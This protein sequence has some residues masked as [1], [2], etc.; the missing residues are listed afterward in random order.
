M[1]AGLAA[2]LG[3]TIGG[4]LTGGAAV[5]AQVWAS[6][7]QANAAKEAHLQEDRLWHR[8]Q[9]LEAHHKFL[10]QVNR[11]IHAAEA[12]A[13]PSAVAPNPVA[14]ES[15]FREAMALTVD[16]YNLIDLVSLQKELAAQVMVA[17]QTDGFMKAGEFEGVV[18]AIGEAS[19]IYRDAARA[20]LKA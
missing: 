9:R 20:E 10:N 14:V 16:A 12:V 11:L 13:Y 6:R 19:R 15:D 1:D 18:R 3:A 4:L 2:L 8:D 5:G 7:S 17:A